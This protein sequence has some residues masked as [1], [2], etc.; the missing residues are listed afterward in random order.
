MTLIQKTNDTLTCTE[1][2]GAKFRDGIGVAT[3]C[4]N[5]QC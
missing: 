3:N 4:N 1:N 2:K 5:E